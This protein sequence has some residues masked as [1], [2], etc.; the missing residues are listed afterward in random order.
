MCALSRLHRPCQKEMWPCWCNLLYKRIISLIC[1]K[2]N[3]MSY[4]LCFFFYGKSMAFLELSHLKS[5]KKKAYRYSFIKM[6]HSRRRNSIYN[7]NVIMSY[8]Y[9][10]L[11]PQCLLYIIVD[12]FGNL[13]FIDLANRFYLMQ[14]HICSY[15]YYI[16]W[17]KYLKYILG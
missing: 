13:N 7:L 1:P 2:I 12:V 3:L 17:M 5:L 10:P 11:P 4:Y 14:M 16:L 8:M 15:R 6:S 9:V